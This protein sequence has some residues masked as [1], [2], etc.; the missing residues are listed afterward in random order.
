VLLTFLKRCSLLDAAVLRRPD[1]VFPTDEPVSPLA[2]SVSDSDRSSISGNAEQ[3]PENGADK[4][5]EFPG[6]RPEIS[7]R[8]GKK[9]LIPVSRF[10]RACHLASLRNF[11]IPGRHRAKRLSSF[12]AS[13]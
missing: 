1:L 8:T 12:D 4:T 13:M 11:S 3:L 9:C 6:F 10:D 2:N 5:L 7:L